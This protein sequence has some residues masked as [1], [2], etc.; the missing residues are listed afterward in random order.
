[1][2]NHSN[3]MFKSS[4]SQ[5]DW[6]SVKSLK[7]LNASHTVLIDQLMTSLLRE[8][9][10]LKCIK[11]DLKKRQKK[12]CK[13]DSKTLILKGLTKQREGPYMAVHRFK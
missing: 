10:S 9:T 7:A 11:L 3:T 8:F 2:Q 5:A 4:L 6:A 1:M 12:N 13:V